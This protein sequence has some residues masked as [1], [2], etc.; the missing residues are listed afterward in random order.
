MRGGVVLKN[1]EIILPFTDVPYY[2]KIFIVRSK[3]NGLT[4]SKP[5][6][7]AKGK[8]KEFEEPSIKILPNKNLFMLL[9]E[10]KSKIL[11]SLFS[12][13]E[14]KTWSNPKKTKIVG[15]PADLTI[16]NKNLL[17][18][19]TGNRNKP[20]QILIYLSENFGKNWNKK[21]I[22]SNNLN[23]KDLGYPSIKQRKNGDIVVVY[24][25]QNQDG[26]TSILQKTIKLQ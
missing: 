8:N 3:D 14:G 25:A 1:K 18:C 19:V 22:L 26:I 11:H 4:W 17:A 13:D 21:I 16:V 5:K 10:N 6:L 23:N 24:Y 15:Y 7:V 9:R 20:H 12:K 2:K